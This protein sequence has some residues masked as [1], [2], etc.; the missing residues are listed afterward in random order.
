VV[1][2]CAKDA[3]YRPAW[4]AEGP[5]GRWPAAKFNSIHY[6]VEERGGESMGHRFDEG[7][8]GG[9]DGSAP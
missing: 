4:Q 7:N 8:R 6:D 2:G 1:H 9:S 3:F 5:G